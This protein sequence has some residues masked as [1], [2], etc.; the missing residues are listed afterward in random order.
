MMRRNDEEGGLDDLV[1]AKNKARDKTWYN[2]ASRK[3]F[4]T[5][6]E[7]KMETCFI[8]IISLFEESF[9]TLWGH[10]IKEK[11]DRQIK[12][13]QIWDEC[14]QK[15]LDHANKQKRALQK[16][17]DEYDFYWK[18]YTIQTNNMNTEETNYYEEEN[19]N[20]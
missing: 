4:S 15:I 10:K 1:R 6:A 16:E 9:G 5:I 14:R 19:F 20:K 11:T 3:R 13:K 2:D 8:G 18:R 12:N 17:I 7:K